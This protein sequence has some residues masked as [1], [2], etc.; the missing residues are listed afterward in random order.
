[1]NLHTCDGTFLGLQD[2]RLDGIQDT[3]LGS[4]AV[5]WGLAVDAVCRSVLGS[6]VAAA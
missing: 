5:G 4:Y 2:R 6:M 1:M 3:C